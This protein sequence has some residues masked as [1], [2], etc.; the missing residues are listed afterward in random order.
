M[1]FPG[2][3]ALR[4]AAV[5]ST[6]AMVLTLAACGG[7]AS[8]PT[9]NTSQSSAA[10]ASVPTAPTTQAVAAATTQ[11]VTTP[12]PSTAQSGIGGGSQVWTAEQRADLVTA[13]DD[14]QALAA[15]NVH[16]ACLVAS[17]VDKTDPT[18]TLAY[19]KAW[20]GPGP[21]PTDPATA[22]LATAVYNCTGR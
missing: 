18:S 19:I 9:A 4:A 8:T 12:T 1:Q 16:L 22:L 2:T 13:Y 14:N 20:S 17:L 7:G 15:N 6:A 5:A 11:S 3:Q 10:S 21:T